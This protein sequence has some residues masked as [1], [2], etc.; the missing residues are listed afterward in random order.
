VL[1]VA[2]RPGAASQTVE[3]QI[4]RLGLG[5]RV[6]L[7]GRRSDVPRLLGAADVFVFPSLFEGLG[8][9]LLQAMGRALPVVI[10]DRRPMSDVV[11]GD[12]T[13]VLVP[14]EDPGA[15]ATAVTSLFSDPAERARLGAAARQEVAANYDA[16]EVAARVERF[17]RRALDAGNG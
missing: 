10:T 12:V 4:E 17:Y 1:L 5:D 6:L 3:A 7:L 8:V 15:I 16:D 13:G 14:A 2:G 11:E 9:S